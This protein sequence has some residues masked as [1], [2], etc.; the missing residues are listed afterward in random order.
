VKNNV[1]PYFTM[2]KCVIS[3]LGEWVA[4]SFI[5]SLVMGP[6]NYETLSNPLP[7]KYKLHV[8][9]WFYMTI[10]HPKKSFGMNHN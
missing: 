7:L 5:I 6:S 9:T 3:I 4:Q 10:A 1:N 8:F 2:L